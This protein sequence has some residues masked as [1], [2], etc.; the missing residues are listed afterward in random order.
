MEILTTPLEDKKIIYPE[1]II[2]QTTVTGVNS[3]RYHYW[4]HL[5]V[6]RSALD[7]LIYDTKH[8]LLSEELT[9][10]AHVVASDS[11][12]LP[13][14]I[15]IISSSVRWSFT[16][17]QHTPSSICVLSPALHTFSNGYA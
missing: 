10:E 8:L 2:Q 14:L 12:S 1:S 15:S 4:M 3:A 16:H 6:V 7:H 5:D 13:L 9:I 17:S 11:L